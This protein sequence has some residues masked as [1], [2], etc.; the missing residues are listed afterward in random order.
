M[1]DNLGRLGV[2]TLGAVNLRVMDGHQGPISE[3]WEVLAEL[4]AERLIGDLGLS[5]VTAEQVAEVQSIAPVVCVQNLSNIAQRDDDALIESRA[6]QGVFYVPYVPLGGFY[7][8][9][10][11]RALPGRRALRRHGSPGRAGVAA[12]TLPHHPAD[13]WDQLGAAPGGERRRPP[14]EAQR[15]GRR[16]A[17]RSARLRFRPVLRAVLLSG[18]RLTSLAR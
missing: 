11:D 6:E 10:P 13:P 16:D 9:G 4:Q 2:E 18:T 8:A 12:A 14:P 5:T 3:Q 7:P 15:R 17:G 1:H